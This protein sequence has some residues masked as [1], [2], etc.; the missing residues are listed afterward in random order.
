MTWQDGSWDTL[1]LD[2]IPLIGRVKELKIKPARKVERSKPE[3]ADN[4]Q[5]KDQGYQGAKIDLVLEMW[6]KAQAE[7]LGALLQAFSPRQPGA[8]ASPHTI[9]HPIAAATNVTRVYVESYTIG[10]PKKQRL[11][12][13]VEMYEW[14]PPAPPKPTKSGGGNGA[15]D[16]NLK[17]NNVGSGGPFGN[18]YVPPPSPA[19][20][21]SYVP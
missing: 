13:A 20:V 16:K 7:S 1:Y 14:F 9:S 17:E 11:D 3:G 21:G 8:L 5:T 18:G 10:M 4:P 12:V 2:G 15:L 19:N 6:T